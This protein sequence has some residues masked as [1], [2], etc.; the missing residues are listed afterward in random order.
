MAASGGARLVG[1]FG[2]QAELAALRVEADAARAG[3]TRL[4]LVSGEPG[5]GKTTLAARFA[6]RLAVEGFRVVR[7]A[8]ASIAGAPDLLPWHR[9]L[10]DLSQPEPVSTVDTDDF[11]QVAATAD[12]LAE[13]ARTRPLLVVIDDLHRAGDLTAAPLAYLTELA[14]AVPLLLLGLV[15]EPPGMAAELTRASTRLVLRGLSAEEAGELAAK[16]AAGP[17]PARLVAE[18]TRRCD[19]N[20]G[21]LCDLVRRLDGTRLRD[22]GV[23]RLVLDWPAD[24]RAAAQ[25]ALAPL[26][27]PT[28]EVLETASVIGREFDLAILERILA[29]GPDPIRAVDLALAHGVL[30]ARSSQVFAFRRALVREVLYDSLGVARRTALHESVAA[31]L[32]DFR[33]HVGER[34]PTV[35]EFAHHLIA[36]AAL[37]GD[38]RLDQAITYATAAAV[39][40]AADGRH[41]DACA[42]HETALDLAVRAGWP[43]APLGR[44]TVALGRAY[45]TAGNAPKGRA[46][47]S[48]AARTARQIGDPG[49]LAEAAL[50]HGPRAAVG[51]TAPDAELV[52][53]LREARAAELAPDQA[54]RVSARLAVELAGTPRRADTGALLGDAEARLAGPAAARAG[55]GAGG[56][57]LS[58]RPRAELRLAYAGVAPQPDTADAALR[59]AIDLGD[60]LLECQALALVGAAALAVGDLAAGA[61]ALERAGRMGAATRHPLARW[62]GGCAAAT[63]AT[64][65]GRL[66]EA[67]DAL[68]AARDAGSGLPGEVGDLGYAAQLAAVRVAQGRGVELAPLLAELNRGAGPAPGWLT[69]LSAR[70][71]LDQGRRSMAAAIAGAAELPADPWAAALLGDVAL[72]LGERDAIARLDVELAGSSGRDWLVLGPATVCAGPVALLRA[73]FRLALDDRDGA[74]V[75]LDA[76]QAATADTLWQAAAE[77]ARAEWLAP[78]DPD[79]A[80]AIAAT[81]AE[82]ATRLGLAPMVVRA[83][84]LNARLASGADAGFGLT[85]REQQVLDLAL[86]GESARGIAEQ[87]FI[88]ERTAESHLANIYRKLNVRSRVELL[89]RHLG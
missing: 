31:T 79:G 32:A 61:A 9:A 75:L 82:R 85:R 50:G 16:V 28:R 52:A 38:D 4:A 88:S 47:L 27:R 15:R 59:A 68:V 69:A 30:A 87:L 49:L 73:R 66:Q 6:E 76:A 83:E 74:V 26:D 67:E 53:L 48:A 29:G 37:G 54:V 51:L 80:R 12:A 70:V 2:R 42:Y 45:L 39:A 14:P 65:A 46:A 44:L 55:A 77:L 57:A 43:A 41:H 5:M 72:E 33:R 81:G 64:I 20:P 18:L 8:C 35:G 3:A 22:S 86:A 11:S 17:L 13:T 36:A 34:G 10:R 60:P 71:A 84:R 23:E 78:V 40:A 62:W 24:V 21:L 19:G 63:V 58:V 7:T 25:A 89:T 56:S 1:F